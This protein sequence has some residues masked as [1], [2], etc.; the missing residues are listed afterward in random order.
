MCLNLVD[1]ELMWSIELSG[2]CSASP[3]DSNY[4][5]TT[6]LTSVIYPP[7]TPISPHNRVY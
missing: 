6:K 4:K 7:P 2:I 5:I 3:W 1:V